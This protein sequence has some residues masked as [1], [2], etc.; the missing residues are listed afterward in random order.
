MLGWPGL[1]KLLL[2]ETPSELLGVLSSTTFGGPSGFLLG[3]RF[4]GTPV[5]ATDPQI[6]GHTIAGGIASVGTRT[7]TWWK[8]A[9]IPLPSIC[10]VFFTSKVRFLRCYRTRSLPGYKTFPCQKFIL[11]RLGA[12]KLDTERQLPEVRFLSVFRFLARDRSPAK[13]N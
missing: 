10:S 3:N 4:L 12:E 1:A 5:C 13:P 9:F 8:R 6:P 7:D 2:R 11:T